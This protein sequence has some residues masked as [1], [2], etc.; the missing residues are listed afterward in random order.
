MVFFF[1]HVDMLHKRSNKENC[2]CSSLLKRGGDKNS[3]ILLVAL[4]SDEL[5]LKPSMDESRDARAKGTVARKKLTISSTE[6]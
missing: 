4:V 2:L 6:P 5:Q 3:G 1:I